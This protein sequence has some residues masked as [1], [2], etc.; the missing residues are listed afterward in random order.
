MKIRFYSEADEWTTEAGK[1]TAPETL[2]AIRKTLEEEGSVLVEHCF[3]RGFCA[4][5]RLVFND[6]DTFMEYLDN[7][8]SAGDAIHIW[9]F[10]AVCKGDNELAYGKCPDDQ[11]RVPKKGAY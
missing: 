9:S 10:A 8:A 6:F 1:I 5:D 4:P 7:S 11:G 3:Y 2:E